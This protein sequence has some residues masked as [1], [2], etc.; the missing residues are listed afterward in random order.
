[1]YSVRSPHGKRNRY[2]ADQDVNEQ[3]RDS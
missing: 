2:D 1:V 3:T